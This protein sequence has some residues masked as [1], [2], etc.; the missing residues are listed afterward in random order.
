MHL[1]QNLK[2][3]N[4]RES[5]VLKDQLK[6]RPY[7]KPRKVKADPSHVDVVKALVRAYFSVVRKTFC[8]LVPKIVMTHVVHKVRCC[9]GIN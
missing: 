3:S 1:E 2:R 9:V 8:D 6:P 7:Q 5:F 4:R